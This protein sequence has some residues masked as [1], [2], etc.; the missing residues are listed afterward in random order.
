MENMSAV[1]TTQL[2]SRPAEV[3]R[4]VA[5]LAKE[6]L[7]QDVEVLW[8]GSWPRERARPHSDLD[9]AISA[10]RPIPPDKMT[11]LRDAVG[12]VP[13][14]YE[15]DLVD[16]HAVGDRLKTEILRHGVRL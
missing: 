8:F 13:T 3:V 7:G 1:S 11:L 15:V 16:L 5:R 2:A 6:I 4:E 10:G 9:V 12:E 14:L